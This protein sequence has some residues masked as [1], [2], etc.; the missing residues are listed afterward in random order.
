LFNFL[1]ANLLYSTLEVYLI[2][3]LKSLTLLAFLS[4]AFPSK[5]CLIF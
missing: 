4:K 1:R 5:I 3:S 2:W